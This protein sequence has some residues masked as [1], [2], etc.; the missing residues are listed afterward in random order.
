MGLS[1]NVLV[2]LG[3]MIAI[4][5]GV[6]LGWPRFAFPPQDSTPPLKAIEAPAIAIPEP[7]ASQSARGVTE[8]LPDGLASPSVAPDVGLDESDSLFRSALSGLMG[9]RALQN[10]FL[11]DQMVR[12]F[13]ATVDN[14]PRQAVPMQIR[15]VKP[16]QGRF[17]T[18]NSAG[19]LTI[20][21]SNTSRYVDFMDAVSMV[22]VKSLV[23]LYAMHYALFEQAYRELGY[24]KGHFNDRLLAAIDDMLATEE[25]VS[26]IALLQPKVLYEFSDPD[27]ESISAG[28]KI[29]TR[30]GM[31]NAQRLRKLLKALR[32][33]I[34]RL[35]TD[36]ARSEVKSP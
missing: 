19:V 17:E 8:H 18:A 20:A 29:M 33:D 25:L 15:S 30:I 7:A 28:Q 5:A 9:D 13:V 21:P 10:F 31:S 24:P 26:P 36:S 11:T 22:N 4:G 3:T 14:L 27:L 12:K 2:T 35:D 16:L 6:F 34:T 23:K 32:I 1:R